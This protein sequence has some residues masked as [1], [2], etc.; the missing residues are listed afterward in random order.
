MAKTRQTNRDTGKK[1]KTKRKIKPDDVTLPTEYAEPVNDINEFS[2]LVHGEK[3][4]GKTTL[5]NCGGRTLFI[6]FDPMQKAYRRLEIRCRTWRTF[7]GI[8]KQLERALK[9]ANFPYDRVCIDGADMWFRACQRFVCEKLVIDHPGDEGWGRGWDTLR[10]EFT[11]GVDRMLDLLSRCSVWFLCHSSWKEVDLREGGT[12]NRLLPRLTGIAEEVLNGKVDAWFAMDYAKKGKRIMVIQ[13]D[14]MTGAG[15]RISC[16]D[17]GHPHFCKHDRVTPLRRIPMG[18]SPQEGYANLI[19]AF[20]NKLGKKKGGTRVRR[21]G[22][23]PRMVYDPS[24]D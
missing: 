7:L 10:T 22:S 18:T 4:I 6:Q 21:R 15:H 24:V 1:K 17:D 19:A 14:A 16:P 2:F 11:S 5:A 8:M 20:N 23:G 13:G 12:G 3:K 9:R